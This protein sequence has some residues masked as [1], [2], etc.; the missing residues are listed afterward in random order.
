MLTLASPQV[1][2]LYVLVYSY[3]VIGAVCMVSKQ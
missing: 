1:V 2:G 3:F